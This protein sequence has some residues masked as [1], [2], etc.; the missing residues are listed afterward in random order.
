MG[1]SSR[2]TDPEYLQNTDKSSNRRS[3]PARVLSPLTSCKTSCQT[4]PMHW[5][6]TTLLAC[7]SLTSLCC[8]HERDKTARGPVNTSIGAQH[9]A[10][11]RPSSQDAT[12]VACCRFPQ[13]AASIAAHLCQVGQLLVQVLDAL[14]VALGGRLLGALLL[15][16]E[17][18]RLR[19]LLRLGAAVHHR[20]RVQHHAVLG[21]LALARARAWRGRKGEQQSNLGSSSSS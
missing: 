10:A 2:V 19:L 9:S 6:N 11:S 13:A 12:P 17:V 1:M 16:L 14:S 8:T 20:R 7:R 15:V 4:S 3:V 18:V 5:R 21:H